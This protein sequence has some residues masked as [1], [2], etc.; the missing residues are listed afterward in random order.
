[1]GSQK[2]QGTGICQ[3]SCPFNPFKTKSFTTYTYF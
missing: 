1:M 2:Q 3:S